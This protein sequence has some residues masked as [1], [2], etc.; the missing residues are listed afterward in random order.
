[1]GTVV[2]VD[3]DILVYSAGFAT[4][5]R[6]YSVSAY[7]PDFNEYVEK[8]FQY[9]AEV[10]EYIDDQS[11]GC[12]DFNI[13][14]KSD[15]EP[16]SHARRVLE[17]MVK[18]I[19]TNLEVNESDIVMH[20]TGKTNFR[21][22][23]ATIKP[24][25]GNRKDN[26]KPVHAD[27]LRDAIGSTWKT[28]VSED[29]EADDTIGYSHTAAL[30]LGHDSIIVSID[31]DL[32]M[33]AG[34]HYNFRKSEMYYVDEE[35]AERAFYEQLLKGDT[36]DNIQGVRG[37]GEARAREALDKATSVEDMELVCERMYK[38]GYGDKW[39]DSL[40]ENARL[41]WIR[42]LPDELWEPSYIKQGDTV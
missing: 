33:I 23:I 34:K 1:M 20:L 2:H 36:T 12:V 22:G 11:H 28:V 7:D 30:E 13:E 26:A 35:Q 21:N 38:K 29:E 6:Y 14:Q 9:K 39:Y 4:E 24:Y 8:E 40:I 37:V 3:A 19:A 5:R 27:Q 10:D 31:K 25:K 15:A 16:F 32:D 17:S 41:L 42:R 18:K